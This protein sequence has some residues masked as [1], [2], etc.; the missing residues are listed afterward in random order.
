MRLT[1]ASAEAARAARA[2]SKPARTVRPAPRSR[3]AD[4][5]REPALA[6]SSGFAPPLTDSDG[7]LGYLFLFVAGIAFVFAFA[8]ATRSVAADVR[9]TGE[10]PDPPPDRPG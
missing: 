8:D 9:A 4:G 7:R 10:D 5:T 2:A 1:R 3:A 6:L